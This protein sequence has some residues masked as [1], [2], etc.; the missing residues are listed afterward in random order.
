MDVNQVLWSTDGSQ[1]LTAGCARKS[2]NGCLESTTRVWNAQT[3]TELFTLSDHM[4]VNQVLWST[5]GS[6]ILT[7]G[8]AQ[9]TDNECSEGI[10]R[11]WNAQTGES[12]LTLNHLSNVL[13]ARWNTNGSRILTKSADDVLHIWDAKTGEELFTLNLSASKVDW[14][15]DGDR[16][17]IIGEDG[18]VQV[19]DVQ[20]G[21]KLASSSLGIEGGRAGSAIWNIDKSK[22]MTVNYSPGGAVQVWD[23]KTGRNLI[24]I[25]GQINQLHQTTWSLD[26]NRILIAGCITFRSWHVPCSEGLAQVWDVKN[27]KLLFSLDDGME[28]FWSDDENNILAIGSHGTLELWDAKTGG[29]LRSFIFSGSEGFIYQAA[30]SS[31]G[32]RLLATGCDQQKYVEGPTY[33]VCLGTSARVWDV[34]TGSQFIIPDANQAEFN[35][36]DNRILTSDGSVWDADAI[37]ELPTIPGEL[38]GWNADGTL[39]LTASEDDTS[40]VW[41]VNTGNELFALPSRAKISQA[42]WSA[43]GTRILISEC[44]PG[45]T[46]GS[47][48]ENVLRILDTKTGNELFALPSQFKIDQ[49]TWSPDGT[50]MLIIECPQENAY[51]DCTGNLLRVLDAKTGNELF[52][53]PGQAKINQATWSPDGTRILTAECNPEECSYNTVHVWST[54]GSTRGTEL[55]VLPIRINT[56]KAVTSWKAD[57]SQILTVGCNNDNA[58]NCDDDNR[59]SVWDVKTGK[60]ILGLNH[61]GVEMATWNAYGSRILTA[62]ND[63]V[64]GW[65]AKTGNV[66]FSF[67]H[68]DVQMVQWNTDGSRILIADGDVVQVLDAQTGKALYALSGLKGGVVNAKWNA[69]GSYILTNECNDSNPVGTC[70]K[71]LTQVWDARTG[72]ELF[73]LYDTWGMWSPEGSRIWKIVDSYNSQIIKGQ[74]WYV[75]MEDLLDEACRRAPRNLT[76]N[77]WNQYFG[78]EPYRST[79]LN[80]PIPTG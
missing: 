42:T 52:A 56:Y 75:R 79:C 48:T 28:A 77:E 46:Y 43:D 30:L 51:G 27:Q 6:Q 7:A 66:I 38:I 37:P 40:Q 1:I 63:T 47:C 49:T 2:D 67:N 3:G 26:G 72:D 59:A 13:D 62:G 69:P 78:N 21:R 31:D 74:Q 11:I 14:N 25:S 8:C 70:T 12:L 36:L 71:M 80:L 68:Q 61:P 24:V 55:V 44:K 16:V 34:A 4:D 39:F 65:D 32:K 73:T 17:Y 5:D 23:A 10:A 20:M 58:S 57:S 64:Q 45:S 54:Q 22:I 9:K 41:E 15:E 29:R 76:K 50:Q 19:W 53:L 60:E 18:T 35:T 33:I